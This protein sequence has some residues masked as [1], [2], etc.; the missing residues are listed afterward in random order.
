L[1][2]DELLAAAGL[3]ANDEIPIWDAEATGE[4]TKK[5]TVQNFASAVK[6][7]ASLLGT[8]EIANNLT[9]TTA[10]KVL[11]ARQGK[12]LNE[13]ITNVEQSAAYEYGS[14]NNGAYYK[15]KDGLLI[16]TKTSTGEISVTSPWGNL[17]EGSLNLGNWPYSF[18]GTP[19]ISVANVGGGGGMIESV[20]NTSPTS[21]GTV[22]I[23]RPNTNT[24]TNYFHVIGIGRWK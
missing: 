8:G 18:I 14:N 4:P 7:L 15:F 12:A 20:N 17:Y 1:T 9:T 21:C 5:I 3:T 13:A 19:Y 16:C 22:W 10:G 2:I 6:T 23:T 11:D 24:Q